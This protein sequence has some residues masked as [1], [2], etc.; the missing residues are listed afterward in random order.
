MAGILDVALAIA[1]R[2]RNVLSRLRAAL[3]AGQDA[4]ALKLARELCGLEN[5][6]TSTQFN[7]ETSH[8]VN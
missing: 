2:R 1:E 3:E 7:D 8:R 4:E 6:S 5:L